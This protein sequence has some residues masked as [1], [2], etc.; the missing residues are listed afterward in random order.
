MTSPSTS[1]DE[2]VYSQPQS[3]PPE[4]ESEQATAMAREIA[5]AED[6]QTRITNAYPGATNSIGSVHQRKWFL[7][8]DRESSGFQ[9]MPSKDG[10][11][12]WIPK[13][14]DNEYPAATSNSAQGFEP[15]FVMGREVER[16]VVTGR[17]ASDIMADEGVSGYVGRRGWRPVVD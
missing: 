9:R 11:I 10:S 12:S 8:L 6:A 3:D 2:Q 14:A 15:F 1:E 7:S 13:A 17:R 4:E 5:E 16:S